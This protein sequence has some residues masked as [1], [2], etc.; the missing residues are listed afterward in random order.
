VLLLLLL[1]LLLRGR[2]LDGDAT[3]PARVTSLTLF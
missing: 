2:C 3:L 1:L